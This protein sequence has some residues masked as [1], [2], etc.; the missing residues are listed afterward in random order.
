MGC[1]ERRDE[2]EGKVREK[3]EKRGRTK[4]WV[5]MAAA[6]GDVETKQDF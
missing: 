4:R 6:L 5:G 3:K 1:G 2:E